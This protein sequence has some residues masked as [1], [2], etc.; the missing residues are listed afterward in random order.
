VKSI[1]GGRKEVK[2]VKQEENLPLCS[3]FKIAI[4]Q[5]INQHGDEM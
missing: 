1:S 4:A 5:S 3:T 2:S